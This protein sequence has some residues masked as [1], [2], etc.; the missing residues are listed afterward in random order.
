MDYIL[1]VNFTMNSNIE[2]K[3]CITKH[4]KQSLASKSN[5]YD[6]V[7]GLEE[8]KLQCNSIPPCKLILK[9]VII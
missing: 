7:M 9:A 1:A 8:N 4:K 3:Q 2:T 6:K 5:P